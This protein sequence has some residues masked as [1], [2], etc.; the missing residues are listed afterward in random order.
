MVCKSDKNIKKE[1]D[2][3]FLIEDQA[4]LENNENI[5][6]MEEETNIDKQSVI[7]AGK[8]IKD[9][10]IV[11]KEL[12]TTYDNSVQKPSPQPQPKPIALS[13]KAVTNKTPVE[14]LVTYYEPKKIDPKRE[15]PGMTFLYIF[16]TAAE[17]NY[18]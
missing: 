5:V 9:E 8:Y 2:E 13:K 14:E 4:K 17:V 6:S 11:V 18:F 3:V 1:D 12:E 15:E 7:L 10:D 16:P